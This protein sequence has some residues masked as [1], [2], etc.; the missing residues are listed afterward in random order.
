MQS[1]QGCLNEGLL[2]EE[3]QFVGSVTG[4]RKPHGPQRRASLGREAMLRCR[5]VLTSVFSLNEGLLSEEKQ[6][7]QPTRR[8]VYGSRLNEGLLSEEKQ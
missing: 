4:D 3:K 1:V 8:R 7:V 6:S 2:S 5:G